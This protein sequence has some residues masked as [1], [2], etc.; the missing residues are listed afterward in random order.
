MASQQPDSKHK[1]DKAH[2]PNDEKNEK[3]GS[4]VFWFCFVFFLLF[5]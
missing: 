4:V 2:N 1:T 5:V 3:T